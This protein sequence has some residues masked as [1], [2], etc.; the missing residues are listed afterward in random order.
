MEDIISP[1]TKQEHFRFNPSCSNPIV[2]IKNQGSQTL[3]SAYIVYG[4][5]GLSDNWFY[6]EGDL[7]FGESELVELPPISWDWE[8][9]NPFYARVNMPNGSVEDEYAIN[10]ILFSEAIELGTYD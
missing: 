9:Q 4:F 5:N 10:D 3:S 8:N 2:R 6:W 7:K 1:S